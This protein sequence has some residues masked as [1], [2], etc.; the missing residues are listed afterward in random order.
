MCP[1]LLNTPPPLAIKGKICPGR[2]K[3]SGFV[4]LSTIAFIVLDLSDADIPDVT[5]DPFKSTETVNAVS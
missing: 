3:S 5:P 1:V 4:F 2:A